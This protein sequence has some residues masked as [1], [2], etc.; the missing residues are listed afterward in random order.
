[1]TKYDGPRYEK[2]KSD[3]VLYEAYLERKR[4]ES[5]ARQL[6]HSYETERKRKWRLAN[7]EAAQRI[8]QANHAVEHALESG[9][10]VKPER[11]SKCGKKVKVQG[12]HPSYAKS[13][14]LVVVWLCGGCH[15]KEHKKIRKTAF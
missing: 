2:I 1:M 10:L 13:Q 5:K 3:P 15:A 14:W 6:S 8:R 12:H 9:K 11:C 4:N 7:R